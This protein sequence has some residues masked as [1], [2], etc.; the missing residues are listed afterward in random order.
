MV[1]NVLLKHLL[2]GGSLALNT[3]AMI[4]SL[5]SI[6]KISNWRHGSSSRAPALQ[7]QSPEL[8]PQS[9]QKKTVEENKRWP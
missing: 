5:I 1:K 3:L 8:K 6:K 7:V 9:Y 2:H 4:I